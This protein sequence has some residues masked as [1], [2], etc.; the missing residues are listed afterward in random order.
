MRVLACLAVLMIFFTPNANADILRCDVSDKNWCSVAGCKSSKAV[1]EYNL[2]NTRNK[3]YSLCSK[4]KPDCQIVEVKSSRESGVFL[5][6]RF[7]GASYAK[8]ALQNVPLTRHETD[9]ERTEKA[10]KGADGK[11]LMYRT[12]SS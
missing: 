7:G 8:I 3:T 2:F 6:V 9:G 11:R 12:P 4:G 1:G 10:I 5:I